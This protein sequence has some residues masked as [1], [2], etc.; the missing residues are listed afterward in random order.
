MGAMAALTRRLFAQT[1]IS[2]P[3][4]PGFLKNFLR[5]IDYRP[6]AL[7]EFSIPAP[8]PPNRAKSGRTGR[9]ARSSF[10]CGCG[11]DGLSPDFCDSSVSPTG[12]PD[13]LIL[14]SSSF[15]NPGH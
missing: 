4:F 5:R 10:R 6:V 7:V 3:E 13:S 1:S 12:H 15:S 11:S 8:A 14:P 2:D 9:M